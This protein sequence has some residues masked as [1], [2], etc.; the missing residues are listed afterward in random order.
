L[1]E[2]GENFGKAIRHSRTLK[3]EVMKLTKEQIDIL[4][5]TMHRAASGFF[6]GDSPDMQGLVAAGLMES[7]GRKSFVPEG[8][9]RITE[10]GR[11]ALEEG[12]FK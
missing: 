6:C 4:D 10:K 1:L 2:I 9:F 8:Y 7:A 3:G 5:H 12:I 11:V